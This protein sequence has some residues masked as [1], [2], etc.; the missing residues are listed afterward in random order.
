MVSAEAMAWFRE[1][2]GQPPSPLGLHLLLGDQTPAMLKNV[3]RNV[4]E[5]RVVVAEGVFERK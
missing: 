1:R 5:N 3:L 2:L 4:E